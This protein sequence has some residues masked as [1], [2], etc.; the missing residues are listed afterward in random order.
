MDQDFASAC[1]LSPAPVVRSWAS[2]TPVSAPAL[3]PL[4]SSGLE[5]SLPLPWWL[6]VTARLKSGSSSCSVCPGGGEVDG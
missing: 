2:V 4:P 5:A 1:S 6:W 3:P